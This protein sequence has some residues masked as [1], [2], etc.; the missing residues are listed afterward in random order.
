MT[1]H[2]MS[3]APL[4][5][6]TNPYSGKLDAH[7]LTKSSQSDGEKSLSRSI[8]TMAGPDRISSGSAALMVVLSGIGFVSGFKAGLYQPIRWL[9]AHMGTATERDYTAKWWNRHHAI[10]N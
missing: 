10:H 4:V 1:S 2:P 3:P 7:S 5:R 6:S 9:D 8:G